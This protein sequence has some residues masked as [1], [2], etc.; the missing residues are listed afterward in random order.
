MVSGGAANDEACGA[1][2]GRWWWFEQRGWADGVGRRRSGRWGCVRG[3]DGGASGAAARG[4][5]VGAPGGG[6][7]VG[8]AVAAEQVAKAD[9]RRD[10]GAIPVH[11]APLEAGL[12]DELVGAL[13]G[14][15]ADRVAPCAE[16]G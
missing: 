7:C 14:P 5:A 2:R 8:P 11:T 1:G 3:G 9:H 6:P 10:R 13:D 12:D 16:V 4:G 15:A